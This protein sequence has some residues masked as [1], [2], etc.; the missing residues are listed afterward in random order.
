[1]SAV[2]ATWEAGGWLK[3]KSNLRPS[4]YLDCYLFK[5]KKKKQEQLHKELKVEVQLSTTLK[6]GCL[7]IH[8]IC[9]TIVRILCVCIYISQLY[10][11]VCVP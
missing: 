4:L 10:M 2:Q 1:M 6:K 8:I 9:G 3:F 5:E 11:R 7:I